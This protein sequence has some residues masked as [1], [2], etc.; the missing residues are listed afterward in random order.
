MQLLDGADDVGALTTNA[1]AAK[2]GA[3]SARS[4]NTSTTSRRC[5]MR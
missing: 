4:I 5:S 2:A 1:V 3:V